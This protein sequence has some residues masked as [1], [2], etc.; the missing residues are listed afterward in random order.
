[1]E[2]QK[3]KP[4]IRFDGTSIFGNFSLY[5]ILETEDESLFEEG[6]EVDFEETKRSILKDFKQQFEK[7]IKE[8]LEKNGL[9]YEGLVYFSPRQYNFEGDSIDLRISIKNKAKV[10]D[11][12]KQNET[13]IQ[14]ELDN[15][16]SYDGY[17]ALTPDFVNEIYEELDENNDI[18]IMVLVVMFKEIREELE[19]EI[20]DIIL[21]N[22]ISQK[23]EDY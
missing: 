5:N 12:I 11:F 14:K 7:Q 13:E 10:K 15:N 17:M 23:I 18:D 2:K 9:Q 3:Q 19:E 21:N 16:K 4:I 20:Y 1:M 22:V 8:I 6:L